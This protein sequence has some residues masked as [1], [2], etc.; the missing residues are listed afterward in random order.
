MGNVYQTCSIC[1][2]TSLE[3]ELCHIDG[4]QVCVKCLYEDVTPFAIYPIGVV[5]NSLRRSRKG[6]GTT[7]TDRVSQIVLLASQKPFMYRLDEEKYLTVVY[8]LHDT[9]PVRSVF[10]RG[11]DGKRVGV[12]AS[13][14]PHRLSRIG[15][16]ECTLLK[17]EET[18]LFVK[19]LDAINETPVL[20]IKLGY[21]ALKK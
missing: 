12:F 20:D 21:N 8:Y 7:G 14:T 9:G 19:G 5:K 15:V 11:L 6:F 4:R 2:R 10:E 13:R 1:G 3:V 16:Q 18:T 17:I